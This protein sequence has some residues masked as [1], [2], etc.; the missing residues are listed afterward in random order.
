MKNINRFGTLVVTQDKGLKF[1][2]DFKTY[3]DMELN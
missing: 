1:I 3:I 2:P